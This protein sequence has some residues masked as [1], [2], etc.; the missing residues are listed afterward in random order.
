MKAPKGLNWLI[1]TASFFE[2][3]IENTLDCLGKKKENI[4]SPFIRHHWPRWISPNLLTGLRGLIAV[5]LIC[6]LLFGGLTVY[7]NNSLFAALVIVACLTDFFDGPVARALGK[8]SKTGSVYDKIVDKFLIL[9]LG[10]AEFWHLDQTLVVLSV[11]GMVIVV[12]SAVYKY[13]QQGAEVPENII[14]KFSMTCYSLAIIIA[15]WPAWEGWALKIAY[16]GFGFALSSVILNFKR[17][18]SWPSEFT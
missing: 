6:W 8:D 10:V 12:V 3:K 9:P 5:I 14:G 1:I 7:Q 15:I 18:F 2:S 17:H 16:I 4:L 11:I 13:F